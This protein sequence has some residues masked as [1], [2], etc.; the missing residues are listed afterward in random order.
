MRPV[1]AREIARAV[2]DEH[3]ETAPSEEERALDA[4]VDGLVEHAEQRTGKRP[5]S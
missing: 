4:Q 2:F 3:E 5:Y 1:D